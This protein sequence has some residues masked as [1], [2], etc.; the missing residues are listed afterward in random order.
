LAHYSQRYFFIN[1]KKGYVL[2]INNFSTCFGFT[3]LLAEITLS[4]L[5]IVKVAAF[6]KGFLLFSLISENSFFLCFTF[7]ERS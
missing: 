7:D 4:E 6:W 2:G 3:E 1:R 5:S